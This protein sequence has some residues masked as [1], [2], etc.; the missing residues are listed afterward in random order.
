E[1]LRALDQRR[2]D[3]EAQLA[4]IVARRPINTRD[5]RHL[6]DELLELAGDWRR[7]LVDDPTNA[8]PIVSSLLKGRVTFTPLDARDRWRVSGEGTL[9][10]LF[11]KEWTG[12][13]GVPNGIRTRV[14][15]LKGPRPGPLDDGDLGRAPNKKSYHSSLG[16]S[17]PPRP[18]TTE[19]PC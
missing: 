4:A 17:G 11:S 6:R 1:T 3:L 16:A 7:V 12:R 8:R 2:R 18:N 10:G 5:V 15:A 19:K 9:I 14:L 13:Y